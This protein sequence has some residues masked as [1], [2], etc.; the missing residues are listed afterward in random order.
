MANVNVE[1]RLLMTVTKGGITKYLPLAIRLAKEYNLS[2]YTQQKMDLMEDY[3][4]SLTD[5]G[6]VKQ[7]TLLSFF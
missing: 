2:H 4:K 6:R 7:R 1:E 5:N 3:V